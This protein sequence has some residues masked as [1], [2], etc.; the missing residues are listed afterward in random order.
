MNRRN[1]FKKIGIACAVVVVTPAAL[2][3]AKEPGIRCDYPIK[4]N[5]VKHAED[6][7]GIPH[8]V[9]IGHNGQYRI[10]G[11]HSITAVR[12]RRGGRVYIA[13]QWYETSNK[14]R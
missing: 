10:S 5:R 2:V 6:S 9:G 12:G 11:E 13:G 14:R 4:W 8:W 3:K 1:F 7:F